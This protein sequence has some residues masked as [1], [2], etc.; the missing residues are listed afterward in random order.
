MTHNNG[1]LLAT[2]RLA[3]HRRRGERRK[4][5]ASEFSARMIAGC[6]TTPMSRNVTTFTWRICRA[7]RNRE[8]YMGSNIDDSE[9][10]AG[11]GGIF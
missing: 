2:R 11:S 7:F 6:F 3:W 9:R 4:P 5:S 10:Q 8:E 1:R